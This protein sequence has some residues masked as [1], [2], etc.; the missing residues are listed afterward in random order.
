MMS[1]RNKN[2]A[3][4]SHSHNHGSNADVGRENKKSTLEPVEINSDTVRNARRKKFNANVTCSY[5][6]K[7]GHVAQDCYRLIRYPE[8]YQPKEFSGNIMGNAAV[9][10][11][12]YGVGE[13]DESII[14]QFSQKQISQIKK[15]FKQGRTREERSDWIVD[16]G[17]SEHMCFNFTS[18]LNLIPLP[19]PVTINLP[20]FFKIQVTHT[21][22]VP[23]FPDFTL[24]NVL[25]VPTFRYNLLSVHQLYSQFSYSLLFNLERCIM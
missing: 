16:S 19:V 6:L 5:C 17:A 3:S 8:E 18:F 9:G 10:D 25:F 1:I 24:Q 4:A 2:Q 23:I 15:I 12:D 20:N 14:D 11:E 22:R 13:F 21:G 7:L